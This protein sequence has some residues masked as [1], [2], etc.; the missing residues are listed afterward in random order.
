MFAPSL[1][2]QIF[3]FH[4]TKG[5]KKRFHTERNGRACC[6]RLPR[7]A[8]EGR[9]D[10]YRVPQITQRCGLTTLQRHRLFYSSR[11]NSQGLEL[12]DLQKQTTAEQHQQQPLI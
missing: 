11:L 10:L 12:I 2:W 6:Q 1:S 3:A 7:R 5:P 8:T 9:P 4:Y